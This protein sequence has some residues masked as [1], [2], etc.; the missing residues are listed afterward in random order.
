MDKYNHKFVELVAPLVCVQLPKDTGVYGSLITSFNQFDISHKIWDNSVLKNRLLNT[1]FLINCQISLTPDQLPVLLDEKSPEEHSLL[2]P[3]NVKSDLFPNGVLSD[4]WMDKYRSV[5]PFAFIQV[6]ELLD[7]PDTDEALAAKLN[8]LKNS[9]SKLNIKFIGIIISQSNDLLVD[10]TRV[11]KL[12]QLTGLTRLTGLLYLNSSNSEGVDKEADLLVTGLLS[13]IKSSGADFYKN[14]EHSIK[15][16]HKKYYSIPSSN[17]VDT[18]VELTPKFLESRNLLKQGF[19]SQFAQPHN[20]D[21]C[22]KPFEMGYQILIEILSENYFEF[23]KDKV[24]SHDLELYKQLR[25]LIDIVAFNIIRAYLSIEEPIIA[26]KKHAAHILNIINAVNNKIDLHQWI[27]IQYEWLSELLTLVPKSILTNTSIASYRK[28]HKNS[29][30]VRFFGGIKIDNGTTEILLNPGL[31]Y[32]KAVSYLAKSSTKNGDNDLDYLKCYADL[33]SITRQKLS[34]LHKASDTVKLIDGDDASVEST[35]KYIN[36]LLAEEY[37][38]DKILPKDI[39]KAI[40]H[41]HKAMADLGSWDII[42][43]TIFERLLRCYLDLENMDEALKLVL[44][45]PSAKLPQVAPNHSG[46]IDLSRVSEKVSLDNSLFEIK[47]LFTDAKTCRGVSDD[48]TVFDELVVQAYITPKVTGDISHWF[49]DDD[50]SV[51]LLVDSIVVKFEMADN[52]GSSKGLHDMRITNVGSVPNLSLQK[53]GE[54]GTAN[55][56]MFNKESNHNCK[57]VE[58]SQSV[59]KSGVYKIS[60]LE[61]QSRMLIESLKKTIEVSN[62]TVLDED[63][64]KQP[65]LYTWYY[66]SNANESLI[67]VPVELK[68]PLHRTVSVNPVK[69]NVI[70]TMNS[71]NINAIILGEK[72]CIPLQIEFK[73]EKK[74]NYS[75]LSLSPRVKVECNEEEGLSLMSPTVNFEGLKDD[76]PLI[77][78]ELDKSNI[79]DINLFVGIHS[80]SLHAEEVLKQKSDK[81]YKIV[82]D[83]KTLVTEE[84]E[85]DLE[86]NMTTPRENTTMYPMAIYDTAHYELPVLNVPFKCKFAIR[87]RYR[88]GEAND[89]PNPFILHDDE[90]NHLSM[91][92]VTRLW[93][94][95]LTLIDNLPEDNDNLDVMDI[96]FSL[97]TKNSE[98]LVEVLPDD[99]KYQQQFTTKSK[100]GVSHRNVN[101]NASAR[102]KW[103]RQ[104]SKDINEFE[105]EEWDILLP[106]SDPRVLL[107]VDKLEPEHENNK[108]VKLKYIIENPTPRIFS[109]STKLVD[110]NDRFIWN[111][112][113]DER[114]ILPLS[115]PK[116]PVLPFN[117]YIMEYYARY[118]SGEEMIQLP[119]LKVYDVQY[120]VSLPTLPVANDISIRD[121]NTLYWKGKR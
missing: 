28:K 38:S 90:Q 25:T 15:N 96:D 58:L 20:L 117:R 111:F 71:T 57:V 78:K 4:K 9:Y 17:N 60:Q 82:I 8:D 98:I 95:Y 94:G 77:L 88:E 43:S 74:L 72:L 80:S 23:S 47:T 12:R 14:I 37:I 119:L 92:I 30:I 108:A 34:L 50:I 62:S 76:E 32:M 83:L 70:V 67:S 13:N 89:M 55:L 53:V 68:D 104:T 61:V 1:K 26:L 81:S 112:D 106:L 44:S 27:S 10:D 115:Q 86:Y 41:Y 6:F 40:E 101:V 105:T 64:L 84:P 7:D 33:Q 116:F 109:F 52:K 18:T 56:I 107:T 79:K 2:S 46:S 24:S 97:K 63:S 22:I 3:F 54:S 120:K 51:S 35:L 19:I 75:E 100:N 21:A 93:Q 16:R 11:T 42:C 36:F 87:P 49:K 114:N 39:D 102:I 113:D 85:N 99:N 65:E 103:K 45:I 69:P 31:I 5:K 66:K 29:K 48:V 59:Q 73:N 121:N 110:E 91:P 118:N